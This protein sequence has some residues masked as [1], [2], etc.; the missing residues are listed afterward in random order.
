MLVS[1]GET[2]LANIRV[3][4]Y[5]FVKIILINIYKSFL[6]FLIVWRM[7]IFD[8]DYEERPPL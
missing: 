2:L 4:S 6:F 8:K 7:L 3:L 1:P 5:L